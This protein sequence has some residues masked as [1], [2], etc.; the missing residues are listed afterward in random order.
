MK[1][2]TA[3]YTYE[4]NLMKKQIKVQAITIAVLILLAMISVFYNM[5][6]TVNNKELKNQIEVCSY[7]N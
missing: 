2:L 6:L 1:N 4:Y 3:V 5:R 7:G